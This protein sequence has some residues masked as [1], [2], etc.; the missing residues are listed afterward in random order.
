MTDHLNK[1]FHSEK[2]DQ[3]SL[4][5]SGDKGKVAPYEPCAI[6][7]ML[8][9]GKKPRVM[10]LLFSTVNWGDFGQFLNISVLSVYNKFLDETFLVVK[11]SYQSV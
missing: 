2:S 6:L 1:N 7:L 9:L 3:T 8:L 11:F 10:M 5:D 4:S